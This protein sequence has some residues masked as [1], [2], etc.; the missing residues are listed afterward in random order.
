M[1][2]KETGGGRDI[3]RGSETG[4]RETGGVE[5]RNAVQTEKREREETRCVEEDEG[6]NEVRELDT[7]T[8]TRYCTWPH[9]NIWIGTHYVTFT[10]S[11]PPSNTLPSLPYRCSPHVLII[12]PTFT[13]R[14]PVT[15]IMTRDFSTTPNW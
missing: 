10:Q 8:I 6:R 14:L 11:R 2:R 5:G 13:I 12:I 4:E 3:E 15:L 9:N 1:Q 7:R